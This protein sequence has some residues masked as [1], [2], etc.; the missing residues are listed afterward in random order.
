MNHL[1]CSFD[2]FFFRTK[3]VQHRLFIAFGSPQTYS[4]HHFL[5]MPISVGIN[6]PPT[7][8]NTFYSKKSSSPVFRS[9]QITSILIY[10]HFISSF[11]TIQLSNGTGIILLPWKI[12]LSFHPRT[13]S[14]L[15][16]T[17]LP[18]TQLG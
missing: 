4:N 5:Q 11:K 3:F 6:H 16:C 8:S 10:M 14:D 1:C 2:P 17:P 7:I 15:K 13:G 12:F 9:I 18:I